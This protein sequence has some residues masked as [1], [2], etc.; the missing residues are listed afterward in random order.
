MQLPSESDHSSRRLAQRLGDVERVERP[1]AVALEQHVVDRHRRGPRRPGEMDP[2]ALAPGL[3]LEPDQV[4]VVRRHVHHPAV[5]RGRR[6]HAA[7]ALGA[8]LGD[9]DRPDE[10][11][12]RVGRVELHDLADLLGARVVPLELAPHVEEAL[13]VDDDARVRVVAGPEPEDAVRSSCRRRAPARRPT[14]ARGRPSWRSRRRRRS[15]R[16]SSRSR[17][18]SP[19]AP[20]AA[21]RRTR[22]RSPRPSGRPAPGR[23]GRSRG[24]GGS[25]RTRSSRRPRAGSRRRRAAP[26]PSRCSRR[27]SARW[28]WRRAATGP[29]APRGRARSR[30]GSRPASPRSRAG[31]RRDRSRPSPSRGRRSAGWRGSARRC[32]RR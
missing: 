13:L 27:G 2:P 5:D 9:R 21:R 17:R 20:R 4:A 28:C 7:G 31:T 16:P 32:G 15:T 30:G 23:P 19:A 10:R 24:S 12:P 29:S 25:R 11:V 6:P 22:G 3:A 18:R 1:P 26:R 14:P 8:P